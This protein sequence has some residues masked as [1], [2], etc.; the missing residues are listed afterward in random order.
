ME[1]Y[2][3]SLY[4]F[5]CFFLSLIAGLSLILLGVVDAGWLTIN[6]PFE[7]S[8][9][10]SC[11]QV[12]LNSTSNSSCI[13]LVSNST[14]ASKN[15]E[16]EYPTGTASFHENSASNEDY[17]DIVSYYEDITNTLPLSSS[18]T[19]MAA[20]EIPSSYPAEPQKIAYLTFDDGPS[21]Q[22]TPK[23][24]DIAQEFNIK[25]TF[26]VIGVNVEKHPEIVQRTIKEGHA[27]G[28]HSYSH[29][30]NRIYQ[31]AESLLKDIKRCED[32]LLRTTGIR[33]TIFRPPGGS[34]PFLKEEHIDCLA[35][36]H[37][38]YFDWN[39]CPGDI[40][41]NSPQ[42]LIEKVITQAQGKNRIMVLLHDSP[43]MSHTIAA[44]PVIIEK[45]TE[46]GFTFKTITADTEP[47][48]FRH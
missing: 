12:S 25:F 45:L 9:T 7:I 43:N 10:P 44:L 8:F 5:Q 40:K 29:Q 3:K 38:Q 30:Y 46:M 37:Y 15:L 6:Y 16:S 22:I 47:I 17:K 41:E 13:S 19:A 21:K 34:V 32:V 4:L 18:N 24:L 35:N 20:E 36:N 48:Q 42:K 11:S 28:N 27:V 23:V 31:N 2:K 33:P 14:P 26:F 1:K 39:V